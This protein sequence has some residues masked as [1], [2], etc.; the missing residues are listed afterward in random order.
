M[1]QHVSEIASATNL[2]VSA[3]LQNGFG[4]APE[5]AAET[6][7]LAAT[8]GAVGGSI[9]DSTNRPDQPIYGDARWCR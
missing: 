2:P 6:I 7:Q 5:I 4:D 8:A 9:E 3:D 1:I